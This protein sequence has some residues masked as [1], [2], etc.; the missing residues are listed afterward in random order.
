VSFTLV[1]NPAFGNLHSAVKDTSGDD[2][3]LDLGITNEF[4]LSVTTP[5]NNIL[6]PNE[7]TDLIVVLGYQWVH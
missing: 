6:G 3:V 7:M 1:K 4:T 2:I 5:A